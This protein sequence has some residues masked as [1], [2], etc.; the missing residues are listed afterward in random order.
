MKK[1]KQRIKIKNPPA[2]KSS[3]IKYIVIITLL[4]FLI[5]VTMNVLSTTLM[6][7]DNI[8]IALLILFILIMTGVVFD[9]VGVAVAA[10]EETPFHSMA[11]RRVKAASQAIWLIRNADRVSNICNDVIGDIVGIISGAATSIIVAEM[12]STY[13]F[14]GIVSSLLL[15]GLVAALTIGGK[16]L[17]KGVALGKCNSIIYTVARVISIFS[18]SKKKS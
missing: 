11:A 17:G 15:T 13:G 12:V 3:G 4:S 18:K 7:D 9:I 5:S 14:D 2:P 1:K 10:A 16:A 8:L 6:P